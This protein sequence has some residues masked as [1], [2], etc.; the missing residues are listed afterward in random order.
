[1]ETLKYLRLKHLMVPVV[2]AV[3]ELVVPT[4]A[5]VAVNVT[6]Y[7]GAP[8]LPAP[9]IATT[10]AVPVPAAPAASAGRKCLEKHLQLWT[11]YHLVHMMG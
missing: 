9:M 11:D 1:M 4:M 8:A 2:R 10:V 7:P 5:A 6:V 3:L